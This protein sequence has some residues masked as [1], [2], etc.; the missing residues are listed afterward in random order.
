MLDFS[1]QCLDAHTEHSRRWAVRL[2]AA[3]STTATSTAT[4]ASESTT[5]SSA[6]ERHVVWLSGA[7]LFVDRGSEGSVGCVPPSFLCIKGSLC[8]TVDDVVGIVQLRNAAIVQA[9]V[10]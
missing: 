3:A 8:A 6:A 7:L 4:V 10:D 9:V 2:E 1:S 5:T